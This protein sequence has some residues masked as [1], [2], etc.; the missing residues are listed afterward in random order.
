MRYA[1]REVDIVFE[2]LPLTVE[3]DFDDDGA[4]LNDIQSTSSGDCLLGLFSK[5]GQR[6]I[7]A[8]AC[9]FIRSQEGAR[10]AA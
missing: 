10:L 7:K 9:D 5:T 8:A 1:N 3:L 2:G 6:L 4:H